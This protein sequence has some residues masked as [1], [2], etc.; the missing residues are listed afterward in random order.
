MIRFVTD[1]VESVRFLIDL[2]GCVLRD[3]VRNRSPTAE[4]LMFTGR[5]EL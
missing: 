2:S 3:A 5:E 1:L 4:G